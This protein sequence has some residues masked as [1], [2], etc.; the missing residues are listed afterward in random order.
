[1]GFPGEQYPSIANVRF[2]KRAGARHQRFDL[3]VV[4]PP[5]YSTTRD[6]D[7]D[8]DI[9]R[10]HP[11]L[12]T[13]VMALMRKGATVFFS[14]NHQGFIPRLDKLGVSEAAEITA[15]TIPEDYRSKRKTTTAAAKSGIK[16]QTPGWFCDER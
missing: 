15:A 9:L 16:P 5:S 12:L 10:D 7:S 11:A 14:T 3:A 2:L 4:D 8:F 6:R 1:M 13:A